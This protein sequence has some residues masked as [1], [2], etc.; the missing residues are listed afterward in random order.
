MDQNP[1]K[2]PDAEIAPDASFALDNN[3]APRLTRLAASLVDSLIMMVVTVPLMYFTGSFELMMRGEQ[4]GIAI[5][6]LLAG[7]GLVAFALIH[8]K[9]LIERGQTLGKMA[10]GIKIVD[11][12]GQIPTL[13]QY[14]KRYTVFFVPGQVPI[15]G[16]LFALVNVLFIFGKER[17]CIHD[18]AAG[19]RV[20]LGK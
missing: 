12:D 15:I 14:I 20:I 5:S 10:L 17:R 3:L 9:F 19:T 6:L 1:Y 7:V 2:A 18:Y 13:T 4:P 16:Q 8:G 11:M